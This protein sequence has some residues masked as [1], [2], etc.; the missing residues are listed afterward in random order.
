MIDETTEQQLR[1]EGFQHVNAAIPVWVPAGDGDAIRGYVI[2]RQPDR[3]GDVF[4]VLQLTRAYGDV[5]AGTLVACYESH[6]I[7]SARELEPTYHTQQRPGGPPLTV[8]LAAVEVSIHATG[9]WT[10]AAGY[11]LELYARTVTAQAADPPIGPR[12]A[13]LLLPTLE[14]D[15]VRARADADD[16]TPAVREVVIAPREDAAP[17]GA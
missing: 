9:P 7:R 5:P 11:V 17:N 4:L 2:G 3:N 6:T 8:P 14:L 12:P 13:P 10:K 16:D 1:S 15:A